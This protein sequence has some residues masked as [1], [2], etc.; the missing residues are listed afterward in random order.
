MQSSHHITSSKSVSFK[1]FVPILRRPKYR[2]NANSL[3]SDETVKTLYETLN[4][5]ANE[6]YK[7]YVRSTL[8][9]WKPVKKYASAITHIKNPELELLFTFYRRYVPPLEEYEKQVLR[10]KL[11]YFFDNSKTD[12]EQRFYHSL[13]EYYDMIEEL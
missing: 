13:L 3:P 9:E 2:P 11:T 5:K 4:D 6:D 12:E 1:P 8:A 7:N 10:T